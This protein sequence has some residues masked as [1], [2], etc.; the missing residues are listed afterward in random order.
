MGEST[1]N[2]S[3]RYLLVAYP[4]T[5]QVVQ[6]VVEEPTEVNIDPDNLK[7]TE[8]RGNIL[9][10]V[11]NSAVP[12]PVSVETF[13]KNMKLFVQ[14]ISDSLNQI[15]VELQGY[16]LSQIEISATV[17]AGGSIS[18]VGGGINGSIQ[19]GLKFTF[20]KVDNA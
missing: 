18:L 6:E 5:E 13:Q 2:E 9:S 1:T 11:F 14:D 15:D 20:R 16:E 3:K 8:W 10:R 12:A 7:D 19:G 17:T 4:Y